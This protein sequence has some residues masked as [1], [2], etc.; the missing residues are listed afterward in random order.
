MVT[1]MHRRCF[2]GNFV[3]KF[4]ISRFRQEIF[5]SDSLQLETSSRSSP[6]NVDGHHFFLPR[7]TDDDVAIPRTKETATMMSRISIL[8]QFLF[9]CGL[10]AA[11]VTCF[12]FGTRHRH[13]AITSS[14]L[15]MSTNGEASPSVDLGD[16]GFVLLAGGTG[17][18][19]KANMPKQFLSLQGVPVLH[20]SLNL[21]LETLP[22]HAQQQGLR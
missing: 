3:F 5:R 6:T 17:S 20:H 19:M 16:V 14:S 8:M 22:E 7:T 9:L 10:Q 4:Q 11:L 1:W 15:S 13:T 18:R 2:G 21:F 12:A